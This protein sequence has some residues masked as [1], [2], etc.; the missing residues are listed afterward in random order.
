MANRNGSTPL[1]K[2]AALGALSLLA[3]ANASARPF[4]SPVNKFSRPDLG[5]RVRSVSLH[6]FQRGFHLSAP[7]SFRRFQRGL[8]SLDEAVKGT[9]VDMMLPPGFDVRGTRVQ[10][11]GRAGS[12][13]TRDY[14][15]YVGGFPLC[16]FQLRAHVL[17]GIAQPTLLGEM[18]DIEPRYVP[19]R[20]DWSSRADA[21]EQVVASLA[22]EGVAIDRAHV[23]KGQ[24][25]LYVTADDLVPVWELYVDASGLPYRAL[26]DDSTVFDL[27]TNFIPFTG[28]ARVY[29]TNP[30]NNDLT[31][32]TLENLDASFTLTS[33][34]M[35]TN[36]NESLS[37]VARAYEPTREF[38]YSPIMY[39]PKAGGSTQRN[40]F[41]EAS[42][43]VHVTEAHKWY[44]TLGYAHYTTN[45]I[46]LNI[47]AFINDPDG[48]NNALYTPETTS[49]TFPSIHV[50][51]GDGQVLKNLPKDRDVVT[52][53]FGHHVVFQTL[54]W[55]QDQS[56]VLHEGLADFMSFSSS[57]D[58]CLGE[59]ICP[60]N[61]PI[62]CYTNG[63]CL[64]SG[65][66]DYTLDTAPTEPHF[67]SQFISGM[68]WKLREVDSGPGP[69]PAD[70]LS[71]IVYKAITLLTERSGYRN[72]MLA[73]L[74][75]D[76]ELTG[77]TYNAD[78]YHAGINAGLTSFIE[79]FDYTTETLPSLADPINRT[80]AAGTTGT[81]T[82]QSSS[83]TTG[84]AFCG[85]VASGAHGQ[86][87]AW[88]MILSPLLMTLRSR[89]RQ[90]VTGSEPRP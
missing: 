83:R 15:F 80:S 16:D 78:I 9:L 2:T 61:S 46:R 6:P 75:A 32:F 14:R 88:L 22:S 12:T 27:A 72:L 4:E 76:R 42:V 70:T 55:T 36:T 13:E 77:G 57:G 90:L 1:W 87:G 56:L 28:I 20:S 59:S 48:I 66:N 63:A 64:R 11:A 67:R 71:E 89:S 35:F 84:P 50:G 86:W 51:D 25:C 53:E 58:A 73:L 24:R 79:D 33:D 49:T 3:T 81:K 23:I 68:L 74:L 31:N 54:K 19:T 40:N 41:D 10:F 85:V 21:M 8:V 45:P 7:V 18:P 38:N 65:K 17:S 82:V 30:N 43:F 62:K 5:Q 29:A 37:G 44:T 52:H 47:H 60:L 39:A 69:I 26:A 34:L